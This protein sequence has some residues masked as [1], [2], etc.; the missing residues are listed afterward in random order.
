M[1]DVLERSTSG[2]ESSTGLTGLKLFDRIALIP[3]SV[4]VNSRTR[5]P[6]RKVR[7]YERSRSFEET[8]REIDHGLSE[9][10]PS[11]FDSIIMT[12]LGGRDGSGFF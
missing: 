8:F 12:F 6:L 10:L 9:I 7:E 3:L 5:S 2:C 11:A 4:P 1:A